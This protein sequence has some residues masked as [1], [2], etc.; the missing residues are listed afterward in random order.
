[1]FDYPTPIALAEHLLSETG[2]TGT[3]RPGALDA[4]LDKLEGLLAAAAEEDD[5]E[6]ARARLRRMLS[7]LEDGGPPDAAGVAQR[8]QAATVAEVLEFIDSELGAN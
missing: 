2:V 8:V 1:V 6:Q 4:E 5:R 3:A 7:A